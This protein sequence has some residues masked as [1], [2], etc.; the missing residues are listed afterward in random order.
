M[1]QALFQESSG[2]P[3]AGREWAAATELRIVRAKTVKPGALW[4]QQGAGQA[5]PCRQ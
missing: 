5:D 2:N 1:Y 4:E 3:Q